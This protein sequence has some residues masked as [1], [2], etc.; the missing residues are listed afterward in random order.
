MELVFNPRPGDQ[1][2]V[3]S[4]WTLTNHQVGNTVDPMIGDM[5]MVWDD[6]HHELRAHKS[7]PDNMELAFIS[8]TNDGQGKIFKVIRRDRANVHVLGGGDCIAINPNVG[9]VVK[10]GKPA[11]LTYHYITFWCST[12][13][14]AIQCESV[15]DAE[16]K[17][18]GGRYL[19]FP[20]D[21]SDWLWG[22]H[23]YLSHSSH[24]SDSQDVIYLWTEDMGREK[25]N[26]YEVLSADFDDGNGRFSL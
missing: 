9:F 16:I 8:R 22:P 6:Q 4:V 15:L 21:S 10:S 23:Y 7:L 17:N 26:I 2:Y 1:F 24:F 13:E 18:S 12:E 5:V 11:N 3:P 25:S 14:L 19:G 20:I